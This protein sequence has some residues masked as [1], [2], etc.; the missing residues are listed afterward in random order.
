MRIKPTFEEFM[1]NRRQS[2]SF[3]REFD[4]VWRMVYE[5]HFAK[6]WSVSYCIGWLL[7]QKTLY[8]RR[9]PK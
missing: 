8:R 2:V 9:M 6:K 7:M 3:A 5:L 1:K 4:K